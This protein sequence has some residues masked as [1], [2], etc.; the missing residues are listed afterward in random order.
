MPERGGHRELSD[1]TCRTASS[2]GEGTPLPGASCSVVPCLRR[3]SFQGVLTRVTGN[4]SNA[5]DLFFRSLRPGGAD[6]PLVQQEEGGGGL[7]LPQQG[8]RMGMAGEKEDLLPGPVS[9]LAEVPQDTGRAPCPTGIEVHQ[10]IVHDDR[11]GASLRRVIL[12]VGQTQGQI[13]LLLGAPAQLF[14]ADGLA[15]RRHDPQAGIAHDGAHVL[16]GT[17]GDVPEYGRG[18]ADDTGLAFLLKGQFCPV[19]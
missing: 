3:L 4:T 7:D 5:L 18:P 8:R 15:L 17:G 10:H 12:D 1:I 13:K 19:E 6:L 9:S 16:P 11:Q 14:R 2:T